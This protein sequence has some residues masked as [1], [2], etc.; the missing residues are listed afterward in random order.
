MIIIYTMLVKSNAKVV[1]FPVTYW[2]I[3]SLILSICRSFF[4]FVCKFI[5]R[6]HFN[7]KIIQTR[8]PYVDLPKMEPID[9]LPEKEIKN[10]NINRE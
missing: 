1:P 7:Y 2:K 3:I 4:I 6:S 5:A 8:R 9:V 10:I